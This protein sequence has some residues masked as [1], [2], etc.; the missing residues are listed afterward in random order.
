[1]ARIRTIKPEFFT[2][3]D[4]VALSELARLLYIATW[5]EADRDGRLRWDAEQMRLRYFPTT[6]ETKL[7]AAAKELLTRQLIVPYGDGLAY[8]PAWERHQVIPT[9]ESASRLPAPDGH[10]A[11]P[12]DMPSGVSAGRPASDDDAE[13]TFAAFWSA[14]PRRTAKSD[15]L[16]AWRRLAPS[17]AL[18]EVILADIAHRKT[19]P[20][21]LKEHGQF[22]PYP[23]TYLNGRRWQDEPVS[24]DAPATGPSVEDEIARTERLRADRRLLLA[25]SK[26]SA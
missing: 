26:A 10:E 20:D 5:C 22:V 18:A 9:R 6:G 24:L 4:I 19:T 8:I 16:R 13:T 14:Y 25:G 17:T 15:A 7:A 3:R 21:W 11:P 12:A 2:S 23:A 1:M